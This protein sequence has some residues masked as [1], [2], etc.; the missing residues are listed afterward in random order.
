MEI[1]RS[2]LLVILDGFGYRKNPYG[3]AI[4]AARKPF[5]D[6]LWDNFPHTTLHAAGQY[7]GLL[8]GMIGNSEVGHLTIGAGRT[9]PQAVTRIQNTINDGSFFNNEA[10][11]QSLKKLKKSKGRLHLMGLLSDAGVHSHE[12][13]LFAFMK[14]ARDAKIKQ[15]IIHPFLDGRDTPPKSA[16][17]YLE[18]LDKRLDK[19]S[20][21]GSIHGRFYAM[22]RDKNWQRTEQSYTTLTET[23]PI[24]FTSW[25]EAL[26]HYYEQNVTDEFIPPTQLSHEGIIRDGDGIIFFNF[27]PDRARQLTMAF[28]DPAFAAFPVKKFNLAFFLTPTD[29][30]LNLPIA[31]MFKHVPVDE[32]LKEVLSHAGKTILSIAET[33]K[34]AHVTYF[35]SGGH[36]K[37][38]P[39]EKQILIPS[40]RAKNY[41]AHPEMSAQEITDA[42]CQSL[43]HDPKDFYLINYANAD[44]VGHSGDFNATIK[45]IECLDHQLKQLYESA[46]TKHNGIMYVTADHGNAEEKIDEKT[47][48]PKTAHTTND[49]PFIVVEKELF[50]KEFDLKLKTIADIAPFIL[51]QMHIPIPQV[52]AR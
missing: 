8:P 48:Q 36:E 21:I 19:H 14:A 22:D 37:P 40:I 24:E 18:R 41:I 45:A 2:V 6:F 34:Y 31:I 26:E 17:I 50:K 51:E 46:I 49:V 11:T 42:V 28:V 33:E 25:H 27:R 15:I 3:N 12:D 7:V 39:H 9:I 29:Y 30:G 44:M 35:F 23:Q 4:H 13:H 32:T 16:T 1:K 38:W 10:L 20:F 47:G 43:E 52:M 5:I